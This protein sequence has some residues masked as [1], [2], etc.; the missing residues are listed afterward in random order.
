MV[1]LARLAW[2]VSSDELR[3]QIRE[4]ELVALPHERVGV[5]VAAAVAA[6]VI[7]PAAR[8]HRPPALFVLLLARVGK[9]IEVVAVADV[10]EGL[11]AVVHLLQALHDVVGRV[12]RHVRAIPDLGRT[13]RAERRVENLL[14]LEARARDLVDRLVEPLAVVG[15]IDRQRRRPAGDDA[16]HVPFVNELVRDLLEEVLDPAG[17]PEIEVQV[18]DEDQPDAAGRVARRFARREDDAFHRGRRRRRRFVVDAAAVRQQERDDLL[19]DPVLEDVEVVLLQ[20]RDELPFVVADDDVARDDVE[21]PPDHGALAGLGR[22]RRGRGSAG[23]GD[24]A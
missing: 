13:F 6:P 24:W 22:L 9:R 20:V 10:D 18:V 11:A 17:V 23:A 14:G 4:A 12:E 1:T 16:E 3:G 15:Q 5:A 7:A 19:L 2:R 21:R 8:V